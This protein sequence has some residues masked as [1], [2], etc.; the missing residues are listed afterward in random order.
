MRQRARNLVPYLIGALP[1]VLA[2]LLWTHFTTAVTLYGASASIGT[3][4]I[5]STMILNGT[6]VNADV[7]ASAAIAGTKLDLTGLTGNIGLST[8][9]PA[10]R[11]AIAGN[12]YL[13][14]NIKNVSAITATGTVTANNFTTT[15]TTAVNT[16]GYFTLNTDT[17]SSTA[18][19]KWTI[20]GGEVMTFNNTNT[21]A[22]V[23]FNTDV[24]SSTLVIDGAT[25]SVGVGGTTT[26]W[27][28]FSIEQYSG[29]SPVFVVADQGTSTPHLLVNG[30]GNVGVGTSSPGQKLSVG[31]SA[32]VTGGLGVGVAT[33]SANNVQVQG[34][35][36]ITG[37]L[38]VTGA[39]TLQTFVATSTPRNSV[40]RTTLTNGTFAEVYNAATTTPDTAKFVILNV[41]M[42]CTMTSP[43]SGA[44]CVTR[45]RTGSSTATANL[46][47]IVVLP[48]VSTVKAGATQTVIVPLNGAQAYEY[49]FD[50]NLT[51]VTASAAELIVDFLGYIK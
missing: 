29:I 27:G 28:L 15:N 46:Q 4:E 30:T 25:D 5:T 16:I 38:S 3:G 51:G 35:V 32:Y 11:L 50:D 49:D 47:R 34:D 44:G 6:I 43:D 40:N 8:S 12:L 26:P 7:N 19:F 2:A 14:G 31:G 23:V 33:T 22:D 13:T 10:E 24:N 36:Q 21:I 39:T 45:F 1:V 18:A 9:T 17:I 48:T 20:G 42:D 41:R 37:A